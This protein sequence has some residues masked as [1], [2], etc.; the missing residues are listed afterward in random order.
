MLVHESSKYHWLFPSSHFT[1]RVWWTY[2]STLAQAWFDQ[3]PF[4]L[5]SQSCFMEKGYRDSALFFNLKMVVILLPT[6]IKQICW[7]FLQ[8][9]DGLTDVQAL[10]SP[11][12]VRWAVFPTFLPVM[13]PSKRMPTQTSPFLSDDQCDFHMHGPSK[14]AWVF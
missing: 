9:K 11:S 2:W 5:P 4:S 12:L 13:F 14:S 1:K 3:P 10:R 7:S 6:W 8:A